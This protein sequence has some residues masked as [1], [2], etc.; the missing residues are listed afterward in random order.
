MK[1]TDYEWVIRI[2]ASVINAGERGRNATMELTSFDDE[3]GKPS[4]QVDVF[5]KKEGSDLEVERTLT[6]YIGEEYG[7]SP[8]D[9]V[10]EVNAL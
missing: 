7:K 5:I 10:K 4:W 2:A 9:I 3:N 1:R 6:W 8:E